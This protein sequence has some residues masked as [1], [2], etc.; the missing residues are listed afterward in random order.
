MYVYQVKSKL[1]PR[2]TPVTHEQYKKIQ[3]GIYNRLKRSLTSKT[4]HFNTCSFIQELFPDGV[5]WRE[6]GRNRVESKLRKA[7]KR[8]I[9]DSNSDE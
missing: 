6:T 4:V 9:L 1:Y 3:G 8:F 7:I 5:H 2:E